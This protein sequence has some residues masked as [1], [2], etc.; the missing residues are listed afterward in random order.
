MKVSGI[1]RLQKEDF[2]QEYHELIDKL[3]E[4]LNSFNDQVYYAFNKGITMD[5]NLNCITTT[6][7]VRVN[8][9]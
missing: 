9:L 4:A 2:P 7:R 1:R 5:D 3:G 6:V 8:A